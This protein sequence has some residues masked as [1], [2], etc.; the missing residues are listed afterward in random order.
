MHRS[1]QENLES[2]RVGNNQLHG[3]RSIS[4]AALEVKL[5]RSPENAHII[6]FSQGGWEPGGFSIGVYREP[7]C[8]R[9]AEDVQILSVGDLSPALLPEN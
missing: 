3:E 7:F 9:R 8:G 4:R 5:L 6:A 2:R 1:P